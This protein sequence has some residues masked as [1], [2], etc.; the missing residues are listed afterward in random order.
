MTSSREFS[1][2]LHNTADAIPIEGLLERANQ[3]P[4]IK[5][6]LSPEVAL[7]AHQ[8][9][10]AA[11]ESWDA[12]G[13]EGKRASQSFLSGPNSLAKLGYFYEAHA[14][15]A[16]ATAYNFEGIEDA[17][18]TPKGTHI[19]ET[20]H[21]VYVP[22]KQ[23]LDTL[24]GDGPIPDRWLMQ[25]R[26]EQGYTNQEYGYGVL[27][28][29]LRAGSIAYRAPVRHELDDVSGWINAEGYLRKRIEEDGEWGVVLAQTTADAGVTGPDWQTSFEQP[30]GEPL[31]M[32]KVAGELRGMAVGGADVSGLG[33]FEMTAI[34]LAH[35]HTSP[36]M[37]LPLYRTEDQQ[38]FSMTEFLPANRNP[39]NLTVPKVRAQDMVFHWGTHHGE[40]ELAADA[41]MRLCVV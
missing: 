15:I 18:R 40:G 22:W 33:V 13:E 41:Q 3:D 37:V 32:S 11:Q 9:L 4:A 28:D 39:L 35:R 10:T 29:Q 12:Y 17:L 38:V 7:W 19:A 14:R 20:M 21:L 27:M 34:T 31:R 8:E 24:T 5:G 6:R 25:M 26:A 23:L 30:S 16:G 2:N 1:V 36:A